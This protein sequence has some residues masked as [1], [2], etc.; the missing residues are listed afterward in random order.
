M[1]NRYSYKQIAAFT[2]GYKY[3]AGAPKTSYFEVPEEAICSAMESAEIEPEKVETVTWA[4]LRD[5]RDK[6]RKDALEAAGLKGVE[7]LELWK[8]QSAPSST[9]RRGERS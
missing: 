1:A 7:A 8:I 2:A 3:G 9:E 6:A 4:E 5:V